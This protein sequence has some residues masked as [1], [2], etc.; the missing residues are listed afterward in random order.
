MIRR[1]AAL[2]SLIAFVCGAIGQAARGQEG[3][4]KRPGRRPMELELKMSKTQFIRKESLRAEVIVHNRG[5]AP[6]SVPAVASSRN[7]ALSYRLTGPSVARELVF[8]YG[9]PDG[10]R[11]PGGPE[12]VSVAPGGEVSTPITIEQRL[13]EWKPGPHTLSASLKWNG[14]TVPSN[15]VS[16]EILEPEV[17]SGQVIGDSVPSTNMRVLFMA[18][19]GGASRL[20]QG[21]FTE[22]RPGLET[23]PSSNFVE[24]FEAPSA[25]TDVAT[26]WADFDRSMVSPRY[27]WLT[28]HTVS[29]QEFQSQ[30]ISFDLGEEKLLRPGLMSREADALFVSWHG[31]HATLTRVP[32]K[33]PASKVWEATLPLPAS[34]GRVWLTSEGKVT[35]VFAAQ[36]ATA[37]SLFL[38]QDGH[39]IATAAI[40]KAIALS[41]SEPGLAISSDGTIRASLLVADPEQPR[42]I[43]IVD[44]QWSRAVPHAEAKRQLAVNLTQDPKASAV[45]YALASGIPR[46]DWVILYGSDI[47][48]TSGSPARP[49]MLNGTPMLPLQLLPRAEM[50]FLLLK[51]PKDIIYLAPM[52]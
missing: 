7:L 46:R 32:R 33:D 51:H 29:V 39:V 48:V 21:F 18:S 19:A 47:V 22:S 1:G 52:F 31:S 14:E 43:S 50:S 3:P 23:S 4:P 37:V 9:R 16:F 20:Y 35:A 8:Q 27:V 28:G 13:N 5:S 26:L 45:V 17:K 49:R 42:A 12:L 15:T 11:I 25:A 38:V 6:L 2:I 36:R 41:N 10:L 24:A 34:S 40:E 44:W 30:P